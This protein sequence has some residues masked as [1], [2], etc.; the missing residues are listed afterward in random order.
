[1]FQGPKFKFYFQKSVIVVVSIIEETVKCCKFEYM[2]II[3][4]SNS[5]VKKDGETALSEKKIEYMRIK[6]R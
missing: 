6:I 4:D 3:D 2:V 1:V 5:C